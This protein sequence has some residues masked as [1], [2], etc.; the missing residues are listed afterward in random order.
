MI[1]FFV[2]SF[3]ATSR[4]AIANSGQKRVV[5]PDDEVKYIDSKKTNPALHLFR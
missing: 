4:T 5:N 3:D 2:N 1:S